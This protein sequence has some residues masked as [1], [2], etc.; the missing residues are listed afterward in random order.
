MTLAWSQAQYLL[1][2]SFHDPW[3]MYLKLDFCMEKL[4]PISLVLFEIYHIGHWRAESQTTIMAPLCAVF[5]QDNL[6]P[7]DCFFFF[8]SLCVPEFL[9]SQETNFPRFSFSTSFQGWF[10]FAH[11]ERKSCLHFLYW[12][13]LVPLLCLCLQLTHARGEVSNPEI[14]FTIAL[15]HWSLSTWCHLWDSCFFCFVSTS[16]IGTFSLIK[17]SVTGFVHS[18]G[19]CGQALRDERKVTCNCSS[20]WIAYM[21]I[22]VAYTYICSPLS[23]VRHFWDW[24]KTRVW[25]TGCKPA[26]RVGEGMGLL[27]PLGPAEIKSKQPPKSTM[28][29]Y[30]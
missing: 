21:C 10:F 12:P 4:G 26:W 7:Q 22:S 18:K 30:V 25:G 17:Y 27:C 2:L 20:R 9:L 15:T 5:V 23:F 29:V 24:E 1:S 14:H 16:Q 28:Y 3:T 19:T 11:I 6:H 13:D 8:F